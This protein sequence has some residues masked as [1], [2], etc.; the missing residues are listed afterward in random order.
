MSTMLN[1]LGKNKIGVSKSPRI[2]KF[3]L[4]LN[5]DQSIPGTNLKDIIKII[6][7]YNNL[8]LLEIQETEQE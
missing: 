2:D 4:R 3:L 5:K 1:S 7:R 6:E 8:S